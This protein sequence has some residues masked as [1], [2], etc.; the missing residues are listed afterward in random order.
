[1]LQLAKVIALVRARRLIIIISPATGLASAA[2]PCIYIY[3]YIDDMCVYMYIH[4][5]T[6]IYIHIYDI[7]MYKYIHTLMCGPTS[8]ALVEQL[9]LD[10]EPERGW[11][12]FPCCIDF[13]GLGINS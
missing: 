5:L 6:Y 11:E 8:P 10:R 2:V 4:T 3:M 9:F 1:M 7:Y 13:C 12:F